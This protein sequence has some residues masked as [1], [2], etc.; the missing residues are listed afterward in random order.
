MKKFILSAAVMAT[1][2]MPAVADDTTTNE[3]GDFA[4][5]LEFNPFSDNFETFR[6]GNENKVPALRGRYF[7]NDNTAVRLG[8]GLN[9]DNN[10]TTPNEENKDRWDKGALGSFTISLG[11][12]QHF[13]QNGR[14]DLYYG[15]DLGYA[16]KW[17]STNTQN[18][19]ND[20]VHE[21][22]YHNQ[23]GSNRAESVVG[24]NIL[25]GINFTVYKG[26]YIGT[27]L[28]LG[29][30]YSMK[31][32]IYTEGG[33]DD[34]GKWNSSLESDKTDKTNG[35]NLGTFIKP[36]LRIGWKF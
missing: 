16:Y 4:I 6:L 13:Y 17:A 35:F 11:L 18:V 12:E 8:L 34:H 22:K 36:G 3:T 30:N 10:K 15:A 5:E 33:Y 7:L 29:F 9:M 20:E 2:F 1:V 28:G 31:P 14:I 25:T 23:N 26:L 32:G 19:A 27:E 21:I 24:L